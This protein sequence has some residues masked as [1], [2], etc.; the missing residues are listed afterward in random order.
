MP[1][2]EIVNGGCDFAVTSSASWKVPASRPRAKME[3]LHWRSSAHVAH[4]RSRRFLILAFEESGG[5]AKIVMPQACRSIGGPFSF[6]LQSTEASS[7]LLTTREEAAV[8]LPSSRQRRCRLAG[9]L[10]SPGGGL[11]MVAWRGLLQ[12]PCQCLPRRGAPPKPQSPPA[13]STRLR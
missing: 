12:M 6:R 9:S 3:P 4:M 2:M 1:I 10:W 5:H 7:S 11:F 13:D 8:A